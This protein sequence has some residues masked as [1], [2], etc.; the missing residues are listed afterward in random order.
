M[1]LEVRLYFDLCIKLLP[2]HSVYIQGENVGSLSLFF[3]LENDARRYADC[4]NDIIPG[5]ATRLL[6]RV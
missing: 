2:C 1:S 4:I 5:S 6:G 3:I